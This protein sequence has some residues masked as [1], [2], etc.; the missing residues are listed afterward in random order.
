[1]VAGA[2][3]I[4]VSFQ[5]DADGL[6]SVSA[7]ELL[8]GVHAAV[9]VKPSYGLSEDS[10]RQMIESSLLNA[11]S[12]IQ[13]RLL[14]EQQ[15]DAERMLVALRSALRADGELLGIVEKRAIHLAMQELDRLI[16]TGTETTIKAAIKN[17]DEKSAAFATKRM[18]RSI[19]DA[20]VGRNVDMM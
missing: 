4:R 6:L 3:R 8:S 5:V 14:R 7:Q 12:D 2:A 17:L 9:Q 15:V 10:I 20:L 11:Q 13:Q 19:A 16:K 1:M 18:D